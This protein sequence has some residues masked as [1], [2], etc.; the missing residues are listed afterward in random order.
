MKKMIL[1]MDSYKDCLSSEEVEEAVAAGIHRV[2]P[3]LAVCSVP[4]ADG[5]E[6]MLEVLVRLTHGYKVKVESHDALMRPIVAEY[7]VLGDGTT[8]VVE[9]AQS[10]G[11]PL[12][13]PEER[14]PW[15]TT[16][17][18][19]GE[20]LRRVLDGGFRKIIM[21]LGGSA[22][23]DAGMG[24][25]QAL[26]ARFYN[27]KGECLG[28]GC[29]GLLEAVDDFDLQLFR[30]HLQMVNLVA[31]CD[32]DSPFCGPRGASYVFAPQKGADFPM[33]ERLDRG[34]HHYARTIE[35]RLGIS[36]MDTAGAGAAGGMGGGLSAFFQ[37][38][39]VPGI[40]LILKEIGF[41][42]IAEGAVGII[43]GEGKSDRQTLLGKVPAGILRVGQRMQLPVALLSGAV[44]EKESLF[45]AGFSQVRAVTPR[46]MSLSEALQP[47]VARRN[48]REAAVELMKDFRFF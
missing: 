17:Y 9:M 45:A 31:A 21:G 44:E 39:L 27:K 40:D 34:M 37:S 33:V 5:G 11:L 48:I 43:T 8:A 14:N 26:G 1:A 13:K 46:N 16:S 35:R 6:G 2:F 10:C 24:M 3:E 25:M 18:G 12:L 7:G 15:L 22:T 41:Q 23:N 29:G 47:E 30:Q 28:I 4:M 42:S 36:V 38:D 19:T 20:I 32:V